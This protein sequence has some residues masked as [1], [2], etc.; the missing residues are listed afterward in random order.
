MFRLEKVFQNDDKFFINSSIFV[1]VFIILLS[2]YIFS[3]L[4]DN[5]IYELLE[6][7]IYIESNFYLFS[8]YFA[9]IYLLTNIIITKDKKYKSIMDCSVYR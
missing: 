2:V 7:N 6:F 5:T 3:I 9:T 8:I 1:K 4:Q